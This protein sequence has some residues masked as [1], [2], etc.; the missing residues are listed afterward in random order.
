MKYQIF[1]EFISLEDANTLANW[2]IEKQ[3]TNIFSKA[4]H[5][6]T[7]RQTTR[8]SKNI[9]YPKVSFLIQDKVDQE[10][11]SIFN[12]NK[13]QRVDSFPQ[14]MYGSYGSVGDSCQIH[15]DPRYLMNNI[16]YHFNIML[17]EYEGANLY[18]ENELV[19][20]GRLD[21]ILYPVS[22]VSH[23]TTEL[24]GVNPRLFWCFGYCIPL[25]NTTFK[26]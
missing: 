10:I 8:F 1:K 11:K 24:T 3:N 21:G 19:N 15:R 22:E 26:V 4:G 5:P 12:L 17:N 25:Q 2:I 20:L 16:T 7:I 18:I 13:I 14:G 6:G 23:Y 9:T